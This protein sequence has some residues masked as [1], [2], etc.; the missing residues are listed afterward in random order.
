MKDF[1]LETIKSTQEAFSTL[2]INQLQH[3]GII[4]PFFIIPQDRN[5][6]LP[7]FAFRMTNQETRTG[8]FGVSDSIQAVYRRPW[9]LHEMEEFL[10]HGLYENNRCIESEKYVLSRMHEPYKSIYLAVRIPFFDNLDPYIR[11]LADKGLY[12][13]TD[14]DVRE[15]QATR[16]YLK[17]L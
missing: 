9:V 15:I 11:N 13:T 12:D 1:D 3:R 14:N 4:R 17:S 5:P 2:P 8:I 7:D 16:N 6:E 10:H